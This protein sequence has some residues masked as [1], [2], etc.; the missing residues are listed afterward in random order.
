MSPETNERTR[1]TKSLRMSILLPEWSP[2]H[3]HGPRSRPVD[4]QQE[5]P[6]ARDATIIEHVFAFKFD[7]PELPEDFGTEAQNRRKAILKHSPQRTRT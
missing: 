5:G 3:L 1:A 4:L 7:D 2:L 6:L